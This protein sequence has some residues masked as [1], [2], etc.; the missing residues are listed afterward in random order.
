MKILAKIFVF[1]KNIFK[2]GGD[3]YSGAKQIY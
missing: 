2:T 3:A 1:T